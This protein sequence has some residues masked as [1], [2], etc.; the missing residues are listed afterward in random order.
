MH[1]QNPTPTVLRWKELIDQ[2]GSETAALE[3]LLRQADDLE[4]LKRA[5]RACGLSPELLLRS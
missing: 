1:S 3:A 2:H 4:R 5:V